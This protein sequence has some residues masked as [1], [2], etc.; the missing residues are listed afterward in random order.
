ME[1]RESEERIDICALRALLCERAC[2]VIVEARGDLGVARGRAGDSGDGLCARSAGH[3]RAFDKLEA[4]RRIGREIAPYAHCVTRRAVRAQEV[5]ARQQ[6]ANAQTWRVGNI[7]DQR[8]CG[9]ALFR[10]LVC[11][12]DQLLEKPLAHG[13][14]AAGASKGVARCCGS[15]KRE[16]RPS[17][18]TCKFHERKRRSRIIRERCEPL[19]QDAL[20][21]R[22]RHEHAKRIVTRR[23]DSIIGQHGV[24]RPL[25]GNSRANRAACEIEHNELRESR[26]EHPAASH[27]HPAAN[28]RS[29]VHAFTLDARVANKFLEA[30]ERRLEVAHVERDDVASNRQHDGARCCVVTTDL[31]LRKFGRDEI[32][33]LR[34]RGFWANWA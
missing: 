6:C 1:V 23:H 34:P 33:R 17:G 19:T 21:A 4:K 32:A 28:T 5:A 24:R 15:L 20:G 22:G 7:G 12:R 9:L 2:R 31:P 10:R 14:R 8:V 25:P 11:E 27:A 29:A 18:C 3:T 26:N 30:P 16:C 13:V